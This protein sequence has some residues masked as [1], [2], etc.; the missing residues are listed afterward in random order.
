MITGEHRDT[1]AQ[2]RQQTSGLTVAITLAVILLD[3]LSKWFIVERVMQPPRVIPLLPFLNLVL[4]FN[5]GISFGMLRGEES[6]APW[7]LSALALAVVIWLFIWQRRA[8]NRWISIAVGLI[9]GGA[10]GNVVDRLFQQ[11][12]T[13]FIDFHWGEYHFPAFNLADSA[14]NVGVAVL[15]AEALFSR[16]ESRKT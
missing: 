13:D 3:Q 9:A 16:R 5:R 12:V 8:A 10:L 7:G 15:L 14:I 4:V 11:A 1:D 2:V 6:W